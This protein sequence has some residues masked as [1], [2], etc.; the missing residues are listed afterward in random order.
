MPPGWGQAIKPDLAGER[1]AQ[2]KQNKIKVFENHVKSTS[3]KSKPF[4][5]HVKRYE[6]EEKSMRASRVFLSFCIAIY[7]VYSNSVLSRP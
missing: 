2:I 5:H 6:Q 3:K 4:E 7:D 1:K